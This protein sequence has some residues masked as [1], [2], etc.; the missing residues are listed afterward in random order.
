MTEVKRCENGEIVE[1]V[2][3][4]FGSKEIYR[5]YDNIAT[6]YPNG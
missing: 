4:W 6:I 5:G 2:D 3:S 1:I